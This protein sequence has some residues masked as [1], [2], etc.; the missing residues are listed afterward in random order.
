MRPPACRVPALGAILGAPLVLSATAQQAPRPQV[1]I[2]AGRL[3]DPKAGT[4]L[5][6]QAILV[7]GDRVKETGPAATVA[8]H[9]AAGARVI[10]LGAATVLPGLIDCHAHI[11]SDP[12][13]YYEQLFRRSPIDQAVVAHVYARRTLEA[14]VTPIRNGCADEFLDDALR[15]PNGRGDG[16]GPPGQGPTPPPLPPR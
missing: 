6:N 1:L 14:G 9:A 3:I 4:V 10:D 2:K 11:T 5:A 7:E 8:G 16:P 15:N 13:D 12:G